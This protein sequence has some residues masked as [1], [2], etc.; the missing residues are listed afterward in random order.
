MVPDESSSCYCYDVTEH[1]KDLIHDIRLKSL[2]TRVTA[3]GL[4]SSVDNAEPCV[5]SHL[6]DENAVIEMVDKEMDFDMDAAFAGGD[7]T[8][9]EFVAKLKADFVR[10]QQNVVVYFFLTASV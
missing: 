1:L 2:S 4:P 6:V 3:T 9:T 7:A 5:T 8:T 10:S